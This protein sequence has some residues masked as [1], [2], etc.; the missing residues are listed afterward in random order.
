MRQASGK[1]RGK[2]DTN[3]EATVI[4]FLGFD[5]Y[6]EPVELK[7]DAGYRFRKKRGRRPA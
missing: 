6:I 7:H 1:S 5:K 4:G 2:V 3:P